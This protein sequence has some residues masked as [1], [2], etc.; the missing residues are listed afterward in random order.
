MR[1]CRNGQHRALRFSRV[2]RVMAG[3]AK[4]H[5][6]PFLRSVSCAIRFESGGRWTVHRDET[7][8]DGIALGA[9][10]R[11][12]PCLSL[13]KGLTRAGNVRNAFSLHD[14]AGQGAFG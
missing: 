3:T 14:G 11:A 4:R 1:A 5:R 8:Y 6:V 13:G 7:Y 12:A 2:L 10:S 9:T